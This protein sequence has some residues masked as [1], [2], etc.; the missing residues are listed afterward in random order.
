MRVIEILK[1]IGINLEI[2]SHFKS[3]NNF[4][5]ASFDY[6]QLRDTCF[7]FNFQNKQVLH[8]TSVESARLI[9]ENGYLRGS[10]LNHLDDNFEVIHTLKLIDDRLARNWSNVKAR[11]FAICFTEK[12]QEDV[13][14]NYKYHWENYANNHKGVALEF[15]FLNLQQMPHGYYP[16]RIQYLNKSNDKIKSIIDFRKEIAELSAAEK[17]FILPILAGIKSKK[18]EDESEVRIMYNISEPCVEH[19][20]NLEGNSVFYSFDA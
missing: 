19:I 4:L 11:T 1:S 18:F 7:E 9:T 12:N 2:D 14:K 3:D 20:K 13:A 15:E 10:N 17:E 5:S 6:Y 16:L 8:F